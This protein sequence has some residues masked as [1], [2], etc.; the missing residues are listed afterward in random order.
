MDKLNASLLVNFDAIKKTVEQLPEKLI[1]MTVI[2]VLQTLLIPV[3]LLWALY[4][5]LFGALQRAV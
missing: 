1:S 3:F 5:V 4:R 2:F